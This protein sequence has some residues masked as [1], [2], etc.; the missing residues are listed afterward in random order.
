MHEFAW[1][2]VIENLGIVS[3]CCCVCRNILGY[4]GSGSNTDVVPDDHIFDN[5]DRRANIN[6]V[7]YCCS[8][9]GIGS[10]G[11]ELRKVTVISNHC[12]R[13]DYNRTIVANIQ[14]ISNLRFPRDD[15][16]P[17]VSINAP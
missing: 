6:I 4:N 5:T 3:R 13:I 17:L 7:S 14:A 2:V 15:D 11:N 16:I 10:N 8:M 12:C 1:I 9:I